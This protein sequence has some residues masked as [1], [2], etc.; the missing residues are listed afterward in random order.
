MA[1]ERLP[2]SGGKRQRLGVRAACGHAQQH[3]DNG[4]SHFIEAN[5]VTPESNFR[6]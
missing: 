1:G 6:Y 2:Q 5:R 3:R 4:I